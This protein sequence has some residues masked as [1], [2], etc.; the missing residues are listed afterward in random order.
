MFVEEAL[1]LANQ[2]LAFPEGGAG[3]EALA[4]ARPDQVAED[5][6]GNRADGGPDKKKGELSLAVGAQKTGVNDE[7]AS[8]EKNADQGEGLDKGDQADQGV[9]EHARREPAEEML[10]PG[11][12]RCVLRK[13]E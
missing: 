3:E 9:K 13:L 7:H 2:L 6:S 5:V 8:R 11:F 12:H 4:H 1:G 10:K